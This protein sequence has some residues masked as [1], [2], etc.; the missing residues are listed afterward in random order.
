MDFFRIF[1]LM[2]FEKRIL[3]NWIFNIYGLLWKREVLEALSVKIRDKHNTDEVKTTLFL[4]KNNQRINH[5]PVTNRFTTHF[6]RNKRKRKQNDEFVGCGGGARGAGG[7]CR[8]ERGPRFPHLPHDTTE[9][10]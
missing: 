5:I 8:G 7:R 2:V 3:E 6:K 10:P 9:P 4:C 1:N